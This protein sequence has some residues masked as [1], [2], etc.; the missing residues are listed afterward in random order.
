[1][2]NDTLHV[3][4]TL[5]VYSTEKRRLGVLQKKLTNQQQTRIR[6]FYKSTDPSLPLNIHPACIQRVNLNL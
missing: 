6:I 3:H 1:M 4:N 2:H 5:Y